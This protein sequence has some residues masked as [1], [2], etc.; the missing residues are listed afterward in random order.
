MNEGQGRVR[1]LEQHVADCEMQCTEC[2]I[3]CNIYIY[4]IE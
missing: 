2:K 3:N 4:S 1:W